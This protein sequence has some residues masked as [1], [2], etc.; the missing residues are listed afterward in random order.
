MKRRDT[1]KAISV[2]SI[3]ATAVGTEAH[4]D[5]PQKAANNL[6]DFSAGRSAAEHAYNAK[7]KAQVFF[8]P[9]E[10][11]T[12]QVLSD[13]IIPAD[14]QHGGAKEA[15]VAD[16]IEFIVKDMPHYQTPM[17]GGLAWLDSQCKQHFQ[18]KFTACTKAQQIEM[19]DEIAYPEK[20]KPTM[21]QGVAFFNLMR[22][23][24]ATGYFTTK[25]GFD[26]LGYVGNRPNNWEG[27]P[28]DVLKQYN[29]TSNE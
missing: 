10:M 18:K 12:I 22:N 1:L 14:G 2:G 20:A 17:R 6:S 26:Y 13:Y 15:K 8:T 21:S 24:T 27:V 3:V 7:L 23:L 4:A 29:L 25:I 5:T 9:N 16:F 11:Q 19:L 28:A